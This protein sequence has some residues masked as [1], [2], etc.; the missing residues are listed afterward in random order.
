MTC[1]FQN[2]SVYSDRAVVKVTGQNLMDT[3]LALMEEKG[4]EPTKD[5]PKVVVTDFAGQRMYYV[6]HQVMLTEALTR[7]IV[8]V[9]LEYDL[10][11]PLVCEEDKKY[12]MTHA[13]NL[14]FWL[15]S[16][17]GAAPSAPT[18]V[19]CTKTDLVSEDE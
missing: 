18:M 15:L 4:D 2:E 16:I 5:S 17:H 3:V 12:N 10:D 9:S 14:D 6:L 11:T 19:V 8:A 7:Y 1:E 13:K